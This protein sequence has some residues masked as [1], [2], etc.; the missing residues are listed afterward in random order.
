MLKYYSR[1]G[2]HIMQA[3]DNGGGQ[4][5]GGTPPLG[6]PGANQGGG[7][8]QSGS[9]SPPEFMAGVDLNDLAPEVKE[10]VLAEKERFATL[11]KAH[12]ESDRA[13]LEQKQKASGYQSAFDKLRN[14][15]QSAGFNPDGQPKNDPQADLL[16]NVTAELVASGLAPEAAAK[17]APVTVKLLNLQSETLKREIGTAFQ[18]LVANVQQQN[19]SN[20]FAQVAQ[21]D[22]LGALQIPQIAQ[23]VWDSIQESV[24]QGINITPEYVL[25]MRNIHYGNYIE[26][27]GGA[28][29]PQQ[30]QQQVQPTPATPTYPNVATRFTFPGAGGFAPAP[31]NQDPNGA[32][33]S[34]NVDTRAAL[35]ATFQRMGGKMPTGLKNG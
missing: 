15:M 7:Q 24:Q 1:Y 26:A 11:Q 10:K 19:A 29:Q 31:V 13:L 6:N 17:Q 4:G 33:T 34:L 30:H 20:A 18:P 14:Q 28:P 2:T 27:N 3:P 23:Q 32:K 9:V 21:N 25:S 22:R 5:G 16:R 12:A 35:V 8:Q